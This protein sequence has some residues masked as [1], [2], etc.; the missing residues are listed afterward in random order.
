MTQ[1]ERLSYLIHY[2]KSE[3]ENLKKI[4]VPDNEAE[5]KVLLRSLMN[6]R[7][8]KNIENDF[9]SIQDAYLQAEQREK[10][11]VSLTDLSPVQKGIYLWQ[12]DITALKTDGIVNA[13]N[14]AL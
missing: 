10:H 11:I 6:I 4:E 3:D 13:A 14:N 12:G 2:L 5:Q 9:L 1:H 7:P 8:P